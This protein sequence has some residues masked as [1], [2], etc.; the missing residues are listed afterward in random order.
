MKYLQD[1][2]D[3]KAIKK[4]RSSSSVT[5][6][7]HIS[8]QP[9]FRR[10]LGMDL[11]L[12]SVFYLEFH[13]LMFVS[14]TCFFS[15]ESQTS[16]GETQERE[17]KPQSGE[18]KDSAAA[19][20]TGKR[21]RVQA[22]SRTR[23]HET[24]ST[25]SWRTLC[26]T[27]CFLSQEETQRRVEK[28]EILEHTVLFLQNTVTRGKASAEG[29]VGGGGQRHSFQDGFSSCLQRASRFLG[30]DGNGL[31]L[32]SALDASFA[33][34]LSHSDSN[35]AGSQTRPDSGA[36]SSS[37]LLR[38]SSRPLL[39]LLTHRSGNRLCAPALAASAPKR[40]ESPRSPTNP[41]RQHKEARGAG[42]QSPSQ[43]QPACPS[44]WRPW[45]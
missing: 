11:T 18:P 45:P 27:R 31:W 4:V 8:L 12:L 32:G 19:A 41:R 10:F 9:V 1:S 25:R 34:R 36:P 15:A 35:P 20:T 28:A 6:L 39:Q 14:V 17:N 44:L 7:S 16:G 26:L 22:F 38:N 29:G 42:K 23:R 37:V 40:A 13:E 24:T 33:A 5:L 21:L 3:A 30:P 2:E 43:I